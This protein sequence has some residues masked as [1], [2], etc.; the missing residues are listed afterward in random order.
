M[1]FTPTTLLE[2]VNTLLEIIGEPPVNTIPNSGMSDARIAK[3]SIHRASREIQLEGPRCSS[4]YNVELFPEAD[5]KYIKVPVNTLNV[6]AVDTYED[7][8]LR[9]ARLFDRAND[10]YAFDKSVKVNLTQFL[11]FEEL[12]EHVR[13]YVT[14]LAGR[15]FQKR[16]LGADTLDRYTQEDEAK[17][18]A[19]YRR[20]E[21]SNDD[22]SILEGLPCSSILRRW[23]W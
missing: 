8:V 3:D 7:I 4:R 14:L 15:Q 5:T 22:R 16:S 10:T 1:E 6:A 9:G 17:A 19:L 21:F 20:R 13:F 23:G 11:A 18:R 2:A 12:P